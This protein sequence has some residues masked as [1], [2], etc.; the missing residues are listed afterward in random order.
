MCHTLCHFV[1]HIFPT[2]GNIWQFIVNMLTIFNSVDN[3][4]RN[5]EHGEVVLFIQLC[6]Q[7]KKSNLRTIIFSLPI[8][9]LQILHYTHKWQAHPLVEIGQNV[10]TLF[11][12][13]SFLQLFLVLVIFATTLQLVCN[14]FGVHPFMWTTF[15]LVFIQ[16][17][18]L[19]SI[20]CNCDQFSYNLTS[21][22]RCIKIYKYIYFECIWTIILHVYSSNI[23]SINGLTIMVA[24]INV[25]FEYIKILCKIYI[26]YIVPILQAYP[27]HLIILLKIITNDI[28]HYLY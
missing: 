18:Q 1:Q 21:T 6:V 23:I 15:N 7:F 16:E 28:Y 2:F 19:C 22:Q 24:L 14:Y 12:T 3:T 20:S 27:N 5:I 13:I 4:F 26:K 8:T 9:I 10:T 11:A 25:Y 17:K